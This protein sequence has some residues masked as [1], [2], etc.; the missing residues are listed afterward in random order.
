M[1][2]AIEEKIDSRIWLEQDIGE[3]LAAL[4]HEF[5]NTPASAKSDVMLFSGAIFAHEET[6]LQADIVAMHC[7]TL[8]F[9]GCTVPWQ[10][11]SNVF[12]AYEHIVYSSWSNGVKGDGSRFRVVIPF[13]TPLVS[14]GPLTA[15]KQ[16]HHLWDYLTDGHFDDDSV[17]ALDRGKRSAQSWFYLPSKT[18]HNIWC[19]HEAPTMSAQTVLREPASIEMAKARQ[20]HIARQ[21]ALEASI[22]QNQPKSLTQS[23]IEDYAT[24]ALKKWVDAVEGHNAFYRYSRSLHGYNIPIEVIK[25]LLRQ[26]AHLFGTNTNDRL[27]EVPRLLKK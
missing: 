13:K 21:Q 26:N 3:G 20:A 7:L 1:K 8:D 11:V 12:S 4:L 16:Y 22:A 19:H 5:A 23:Q 27:K 6:K 17:F 18:A 10:D 25:Q 9:D 15:V 14:Q 24:R 2:I